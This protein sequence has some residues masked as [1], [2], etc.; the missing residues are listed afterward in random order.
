MKSSFKVLIAT[1]AACILIFGPQGAHLQASTPAATDETT[2]RDALEELYE[3]ADGDAW[4]ENRNWLTNA[5]LDR[6][7]GVITNSSGRVV[8][9]D[10][11]ENELNGTIPAALGNLTYLEALD[12][13]KNQ[14]KGNIPPELGNLANLEALILYGNQLSGSIPTELDSLSKLQIL[15]LSGNNLRGP[16]PPELGQLANLTLLVLS[17]NGLTGAIPPQLG[18]LE[19]LVWLYLWGNQLR[20]EIPPELGNLITLSAWTFRTTIWWERFRQPWKTLPYSNISFSQKTG[21]VDASPRSGATSK[22]MTWGTQTSPSARTGRPSPRC[23]RPLA[24]TTGLK[25]RTGLAPRRSE[26][27]SASPPM[28]T[29]A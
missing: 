27:G 12:L 11:T 29:I 26:H 14:L 3:A 6:W 21:S 28:R 15:A 4:T 18:S 20:G 16:I 2:D 24:A 23:M 25:T 19:N 9:L 10:L 17:D 7:H 1:I 5:P 13:S 22:R 8:E